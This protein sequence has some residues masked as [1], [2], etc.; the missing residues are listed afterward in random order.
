MCNI[1]TYCGEAVIDGEVICKYDFDR[2]WE[3]EKEENSVE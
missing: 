3:L 1:C 2:I